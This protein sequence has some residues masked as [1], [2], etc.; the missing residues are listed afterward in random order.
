MILDS[1]GR[2]LAR[3]RTA[4]VVSVDTTTMRRQDDGGKQVLTKLAAVLGT[5]YDELMK[6]IRLCSPT[7]QRPCWPGSPYQPIPVDDKVDPKR[8]MQIMERQE[9]FPGVTAQVQAVREY[10]KPEGA[11]AVQA[12]G[13]LQPITEE[14]MDKS[15]DLRVTGY[16][17]V[18]LVGRDG[19]EA[20]YDQD[21]RGSPG[22]RKVL[23]DS[24]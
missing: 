15:K 2:A 22:L 1:S 16:S 17:A 3:N 9:E 20:S 12:I 10:P 19:I 8:A 6:R 11:G 14:E 5:S 23:V 21:L 13:Y 24:Q 18:D 4:M 7:V